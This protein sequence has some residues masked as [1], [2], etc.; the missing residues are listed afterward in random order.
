MKKI[1]FI[2]LLFVSNVAFS[3]NF[4]PLTTDFVADSVNTLTSDQISALNQSILSIAQQTS[5][6][7]AIVLLDSI[8]RGTNVGEI[9]TYV[10]SRYQGKD[11]NANVL[12]YVASIPHHIHRLSAI[13][14]VITSRFDRQKCNDILIAMKPYYNA[15]DYYG[16]LQL[17]VNNVASTLGVTLQPVKQKYAP[18]LIPAIVALVIIILLILVVIKRRGGT[19]ITSVS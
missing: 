12:V 18:W 1:F 15:K 13:S 7:V 3:Q 5:V 19:K 6:Q 17:L 16:G 9:S 14:G 2:A 11:M 10:A 4:Q 8:P